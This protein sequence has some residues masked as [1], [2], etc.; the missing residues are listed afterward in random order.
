MDSTRKCR[1]RK[2][3]AIRVRK[4]RVTQGYIE[5]KYPEAYREA[6]EFY[7][8]LDK[9]YP[10][11]K[12]LRRTN[13]FEWLKTGISGQVSKKYYERKKTTTTTTTTTVVDDRMQLVIPLMSKDRMDPPSS[14]PNTNASSS[15]QPQPEEQPQPETLPSGE[16][17]ETIIHS[18]TTLNDEILDQD[19]MATLNQKI[20][21]HII[22]SIMADLRCDV[23]LEAFFQTDSSDINEEELM[24]Q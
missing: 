11:K 4:N 24:Y 8:F 9:K 2:Q 19:M 10:D 20:P 14:Q 23:D 13:E 22:E 3:E 12:D 17:V 15:S 18:S 21:D 6:L 7:E 1:W 5:K 16:V